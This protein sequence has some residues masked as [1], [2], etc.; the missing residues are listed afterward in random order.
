MKWN[1]VERTMGGAVDVGESDVAG[2][3]DTV[4]SRR[5]AFPDRGVPAPDGRL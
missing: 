5:R 4:P 3:R 1:A 2:G